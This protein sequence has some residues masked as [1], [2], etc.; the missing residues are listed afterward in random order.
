MTSIPSPAEADVERKPYVTSENM[1]RLILNWFSR[2]K[3]QI[4]MVTADT[5]ATGDESNVSGICFS[6]DEFRTFCEARA[7]IAAM[8]GGGAVP[9]GWIVT[10]EPASGDGLF[11]HVWATEAQAKK[12]RS[13]VTD[14][15]WSQPR[16]LAAAPPSPALEKTS[17]SHDGRWW[18]CLGHHLWPSNATG[19]CPHCN[20]RASAEVWIST[21]QDRDAVIKECAKICD[22]FSRDERFSRGFNMGAERCAL[23]I[24]ALASPTA[25]DVSQSFGVEP[26]S[27]RLAREVTEGLCECGHSAAKH[28]TGNPPPGTTCCRD[29]DCTCISFLWNGDLGGV[30]STRSAPVTPPLSDEAVTIRLERRIDGGLR[31]SSAET[32]GL[33]LSG[34]DPQK[35]LTDV[36]PALE[37]LHRAE[38]A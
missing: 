13:V 11:G 24:R 14:D 20:R 8:P 19:C 6:L 33:I 10:R 22:D 2:S 9:D 4:V 32:P 37:A 7:A 15:R 28:K 26:R 21:P 27:G 23:S 18:T 34:A 38:K 30:A 35:V 16:P 12:W 3:E 5:T 17:V 36:W 29:E 31:I 1:G 25:S